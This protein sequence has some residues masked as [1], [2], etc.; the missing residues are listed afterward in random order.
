M[1]GTGPT[2]QRTLIQS[3]H[4]AVGDGATDIQ[5]KACS[6]SCAGAAKAQTECDDAY[7]VELRMNGSP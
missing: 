3:R 5:A 6:G 1:A 2:I 4:Q 7:A